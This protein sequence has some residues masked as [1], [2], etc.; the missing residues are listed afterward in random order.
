MIIIIGHAQDAVTLI[1]YKAL[2]DR[3]I[4]VCLLDT[5]DY[6]RHM[7]LSYESTTPMSGEIRWQDE[8]KPTIRLSDIRSVFYCRQQDFSPTQEQEPYYI[9]AVNSNMQSAWVSFCKMLDCLFVNPIHTAHEHCYKPYLLKMLQ[10]QG[11]RIPQTLI[12]NDPQQV[13]DFYKRLN[14]QVIFK[15]VY[16]WGFTAP[17]T[18]ADL[19]DE[20]LSALAN[21]PYTFQEKIEGTDIRVY[22]VGNR[23]FPI[24]N[25]SDSLDF[26]TDEAAKR[27]PMSLPDHVAGQCHQIA[28]TL[29]LMYTGID[30]RRTPD[31]DYVFF[32][33]NPSPIYAM[34]EIDCGYPITETLVQ[35]LIDGWDS[36]LLK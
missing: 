31:G 12:T 3:N 32:E 2:L 14:G 18:E 17:L 24:E 30:L 28:K 5:V 20:R 1:V 33:A 25:Q 13:K 8:S 26:R 29:D 16:G 27:V 21:L 35:L 23:L 36:P 34:D 7:T 10:D 15:P 11:V 22:K 4:P 6:P 9:K 19:T